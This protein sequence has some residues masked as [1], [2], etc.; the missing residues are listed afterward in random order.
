MN[1][2]EIQTKLS[3]VTSTLLRE[4]GHISPV[5]VFLRLGC[6]DPKDHEAWRHGRVPHLESVI[7]G[8]LGKINFIMTELRRNSLTGGL[9]PSWAAYRSWGKRGGK[10]L[11]FSK[12]GVPQIEVAY[13]THYVKPRTTE[14]QE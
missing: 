3:A 12:F 11:R 4:K 10:V 8:N 9:K 7:Q 14:K 6:L 2:T 1:R 13:A 5:D